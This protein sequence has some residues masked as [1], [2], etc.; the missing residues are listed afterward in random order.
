MAL[1]YGRPNSRLARELD[2]V[3][4]EAARVTETMR[5]INLM[6]QTF[7]V[8]AVQKACISLANLPKGT[9]EGCVD[10]LN[11]ARYLLPLV[12]RDHFYI[13][14]EEP[15]LQGEDDI[16][17]TREHPLDLAITRLYA[18]VGT[19]LDEYRA[20]AQ[21]IY[22]DH[23]GGEETLEFGQ[24]GTFA[25]IDGQSRNVAQQAENDVL[26]LTE[27]SVTDSVPADNLKRQVQD[28]ANLAHSVQSQIRIR[29]LVLRWY[30]NA[31][32]ALKKLPDVMIKT[33]AGIRIGTDIGK[34]WAEDW[35]AFNK[36]L[37]NVTY[38][39]L[40]S[41]ANALEA[42]GDRLKRPSAKTRPPV[43]R[44]R[45]PEVVEAERRVKEL[46]LSGEDIPADLASKVEVIRFN[47]QDERI[48]RP[49][50]LLFLR[51]MQ[52]LELTNIRLKTEE[53]Y[54]LAQLP[55]LIRLALQA[56][57][58]GDLFALGQLSNLTSLSV[59]AGEIS[60]IS[61]LGQLTKL[62]SLTVQAPKA[63]DVSTLGQLSNLTSL[64]VQSSELRDISALGQ[65]AKLTELTV[66]A[67]KVKDVSALGQLSNL[68]RLS[69]S[70]SEV[71]DISALG[72]L[73]SLTNLSA[74]AA[75]VK[76]VSALGQLANLNSLSVT[77]SE[78]G[79]IS[80][81]GQLTKLT[82]L[83][84]QAPKAKDVST[85]GQ[86]SNLTSLSVYAGE[87]SDISALG[88]LAN[89]TNLTVYAAKVKDV[90][91]LGQLSNLTSLIVQSGEV[92]D[93]SALGKLAK[94][95]NLN[96]QALKVRD[97][98]A[99][100]QLSNLTSLSVTASELN[101][102]SA[103]GQLTKLTSLNV[104][105]TNVKDLSALG[106]LSNLTNLSVMSGTVSLVNIARLQ[107]LT[108]LKV[109]SA[110]EL[111]LAPLVG[112]TSLQKLILADVTFRNSALLKSVQIE[113]IGN[114]REV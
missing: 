22:D 97:I 103:L 35:T 72:Q 38:D 96:V 50:D 84:V 3:A 106:R 87:V 27:W 7:P 61:A 15:E 47:K 36:R 74:N 14:G 26:T 107:K 75:K 37:R 104:Q 12:R 46:L 82:S 40:H 67:N 85:L 13:D 90:S 102:F 10:P 99:L 4:K 105:A 94:L 76:D 80:A 114:S 91:A 59:Q 89:L 6:P 108:Q 43:E 29:P 9:A 39:T 81:L 23:I 20:Q 111:D 86:L 112:A 95:T 83:T 62:T 88:Q 52:M 11:Y 110:R 21:D 31:A 71:S 5:G 100:G 51:N 55:R 25:S 70:A 49:R 45:D 54:S 57:D 101:D 60:D 113:L 53:I 77:A 56:S 48:V 33:A 24:D 63:K 8:E 42:T 66:Y 41:L 79:D 98:S 28:S 65:L 32:K 44:Q 19:A 16:F 68:T 58:L 2:Q 93:I 1:D 64:S 78:V 73:A 17:F 18:A 109:A 34:I 92:S 30:A 69:V